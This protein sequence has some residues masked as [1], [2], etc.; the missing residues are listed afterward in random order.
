ML[1]DMNFKEMQDAG[2]VALAG[3]GDRDAFGELARR[4][5]TMARR[6]A[7]RLIADEDMAR[8]LA[9]EAILQ[10]YLSLDQ[11]RDPS[12]FRSW[13]CG[14]VLNVCRSHLRERKVAFISLEAMIGGLQL[15]A[16]PFFNVPASPE[17]LAEERELHKIVLD[18]IDTLT[19]GDRDTTLLFYYAQ[20]SVREIAAILDITTGAVKVRLHRARQRLKDR[21]VSEHPEIV[22]VAR[23][24]KK[25]IKVTIADVI[26]RDND[27]LRELPHHVILLKDEASTRGLPIWIGSREAEAIAMAL[28][29][30][31]LPRPM[32]H[33]LLAGLIQAID[34]YVEEVRVEKLKDGTFYAVVKIRSGKKVR[35]LDARPSDA[36]A[37]AL[38]TGSPIYVAEDVLESGGVEIPKAELSPERRGVETIL[39]EIETEWR[40][41]QSRLKTPTTRGAILKKRIKK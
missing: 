7:M 39:G 21:L 24:R 22:P 33:E 23:R 34:A 16:V 17:K 35:E 13:L 1:T 18:A 28:S 31:S 40:A 2:L 14:I 27:D 11:L 29:E 36:L 6:F 38:L 41:M 8:E 25:M 32:T 12:R 20:L 4:Y 9:Q 30:F 10:A 5:Q 15:Y 26:K 19:S 37:L 3:K